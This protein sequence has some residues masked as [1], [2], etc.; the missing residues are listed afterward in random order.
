MSEHIASGRRRDPGFLQL[1]ASERDPALNSAFGGGTHEAGIAL[2]IIIHDPHAG[3]HLSKSLAAER[4]QEPLTED[5]D[6][7]GH[8]PSCQPD[9]GR[10]AILAGRC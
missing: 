3:D 6:D 4:K 2:I 8:D 1:T 10:A 7:R 9:R 5:D